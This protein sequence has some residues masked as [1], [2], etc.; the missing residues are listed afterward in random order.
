MNISMNDNI[1][2]PLKEK[3]K[4]CSECYIFYTGESS[5]VLRQ[6]A[7]GEGALFW[8]F[9]KNPCPMTNIAHIGLCILVLYFIVDSVQY[10]IGAIK[11]KNR[12]K[13]YIELREKN[14]RED[15]EVT[16]DSVKGTNICFMLKIIVLIAAST[17]LVSIFIC[18]F[19]NMPC[20]TKP[21]SCTETA[22]RNTQENQHSNLP[23]GSLNFSS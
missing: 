1:N 9:T 6:L 22:C 20:N 18:S 19:S 15:F 5:K 7:F 16:N 3:I 2:D 17:F 13:F 11:Y 8:F 23:Y 4:E 21:C 12:G 14:K 10:I